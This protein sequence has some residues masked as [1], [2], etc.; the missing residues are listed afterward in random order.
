ML[1]DDYFELLSVL[2]PTDRN[3]RWR[4]AIADGGG[5]AGLAMTTIDPPAA[6][7]FWKSAG[8][9]PDEPIKFSR[10][11]ARPDGS[12]LEARFEVV[13]LADVPGVPV[14]VFVCS[15][16]TRDAV[17]L[18]EL[19]G[20][21]NAAVAIRRLTIACPDPDASAAQWKRVLPAATAARTDAGVRIDTGRHSIDLIPSPLPDTRTIG[22][23]FAVSD[24]DLCRSTL[25]VGAIPFQELN[26]RLEIAP[27]NACNVRIGF[28]AVP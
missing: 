6:R 8:L 10:P 2:A 21:A 16:P 28:E 18:P 12:A 19:L 20:H 24:I 23:D 4:R 9:S 22:I 14:R 11:V 15:Q 7:D 25:G 26:G 5:V 1:R 17:W 27:E 13:S 3:V